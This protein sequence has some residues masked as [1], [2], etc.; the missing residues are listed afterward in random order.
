MQAHPREVIQQRF[1]IMDPH[2]Q[3]IMHDAEYNQFC[4][5]CGTKMVA[6]KCKYLC[7][8]CGARMDCS[9]T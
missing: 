5:I 1:F 7:E 3:V 6:Q 2:A 8:N 9:D 4:S